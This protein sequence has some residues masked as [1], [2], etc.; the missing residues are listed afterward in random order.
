M[1]FARVHFS[2]QNFSF[3]FKISLVN[4]EEIATPQVTPAVIVTTIKSNPVILNDM[5]VLVDPIKIRE[6]IVSR[7]L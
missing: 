1:L 5:E 7:I 6:S 4:L 2:E 3:F